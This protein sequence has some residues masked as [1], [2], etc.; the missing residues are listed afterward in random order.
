MKNVNLVLTIPHGS[1]IAT[2]LGVDGLARHLS[3]GS[4]KFFQSRN[5]LVDV[6]VDGE[7]AGFSFLDEG[8]WRDAGADTAQALKAV[9]SGKPTK[10]ALSNNAFSATPLS[11]YEQCYLMKTSGQLLDMKPLEKIATLKASPCNEGMS[12]AEVAEAAGQPAQANRAPRFYALFAP[13]EILV[14]TNLTPAEYAWYAT[15]RP[16]K[17]CRQICFAE[18][19]TQRHDLAAHSRYDDAY[20]ELRDSPNKKTK[21]IAIEDVINQLPFESWV[22]FAQ[23]SSSGLY[24]GDKTSLYVSRVPES[25]PYA[26]EKAE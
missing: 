13:I 26:W 12:P 9:L 10:T 5:I 16:G 17:V 4:G 3:P 23:D 6:A 24:F 22:A 2:T 18:I 19:G 11:A 25:I 7:K 8:G 20:A 21:T 14:L 1:L 15:H